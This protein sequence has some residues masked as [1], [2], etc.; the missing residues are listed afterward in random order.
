MNTAVFSFLPLCN[1]RMRH[2]ACAGM[3]RL[4]SLPVAGF[5]L[6]MQQVLAFDGPLTRN[7]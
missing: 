1:I 7:A 3:D 5:R 6:R 4:I 2:V